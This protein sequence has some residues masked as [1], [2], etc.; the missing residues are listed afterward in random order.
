MLQVV[1]DK[2]IIEIDIV[3]YKYFVL[4]QLEYLRRYFPEGWRGSYHAV[5]DA[6]EPL[7]EVGDR[8]MGVDEAFVKMKDFPAI[9]YHYADFSNAVACGIASGGFNIYYGI[10]HPR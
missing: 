8:H 10:E 9:V 4:Q 2:R 6:G 3:G 7:Y 5:V 1:L